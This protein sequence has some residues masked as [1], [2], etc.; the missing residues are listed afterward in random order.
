MA[1]HGLGRSHSQTLKDIDI[2]AYP[3]ESDMFKDCEVIREKGSKTVYF[4]DG[5]HYEVE[6]ANPNTNQEMLLKLLAV[7]P[8]YGFTYAPKE[9]LYALKMSHRFLKNSPHFLKTMQDIHTMR[10]VWGTTGIEKY[11]QDW[12]DLREKDTYTYSHPKLNQSK[13]DFFDQNVFDG[14][15][16]YVYDHDSLHEAVKIY[17][18]PAYNYFTDGEVRVSRKM[19]EEISYGK[20]LASVVEESCV[21][22]LERAMIPHGTNQDKAFMIALEKVCTSITSGWWRDFA[23]E[24]YRQALEMYKNC[25][26][27]LKKDLQRGLEEGT[28]KPF[29]Q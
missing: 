24:N 14:K 8:D 2:I 1:W 10:K 11:L 5:I 18:K 13:K 12:Y 21:L 4:S 16:V 25:E 15:Q 22:A 17:D 7:E 27:D 9:V 20:K 29:K 23:W 6:W 3:S 19:F 28:V 26:F